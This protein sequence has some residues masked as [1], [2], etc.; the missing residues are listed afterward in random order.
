MSKGARAVLRS[1]KNFLGPAIVADRGLNPKTFLR[2]LVLPLK[3]VRLG[4]QA[5]GLQTS[6]SVLITD[7]KPAGPLQPTPEEKK[8]EARHRRFLDLTSNSAPIL[9]DVGS[10][11]LMAQNG[12]PN[13]HQLPSR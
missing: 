2:V 10:A 8:I 4:I 3:K 6:R 12:R 11:R 1:G 13:L 5:N 7:I 9:T